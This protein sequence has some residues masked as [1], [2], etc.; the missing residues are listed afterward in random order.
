MW[1]LW[2]PVL[3]AMASVEQIWQLWS[4]KPAS[5][6]SRYALAFKQCGSDVQANAVKCKSNVHRTVLLKPDHVK[7]Q[8]C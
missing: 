5:A 1:Q 6:L 3:T 8:R 4:G 7:E 2:A